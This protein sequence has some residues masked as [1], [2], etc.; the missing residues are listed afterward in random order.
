[1]NSLKSLKVVNNFFRKLDNDKK[2]LI[3]LSGGMDSTTIAYWMKKN[4]YYIQA[5]YFDYSQG[6]TNGERES[7][8]SI[9]KKLEIKLNIIK[10]PLLSTLYQDV[11]DIEKK[12]VINH[13]GD[14]VD[15]FIRAIVYASKIDSNY[16]ITGV[17]SDDLNQVPFFTKKFFK[18]ME[19]LANLSNEK[20]F[21]IL[22]PFLG[23]D[24]SNILKIGIDLDI[25]F[26]E[27]WS[28]GTSFRKQCGICIDCI[29]RKQ[30][31][32]QIGLL[33]PTEYEY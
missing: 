13:L 5:L 6:K 28:C 4:H 19:N 18:S 26:K 14:V 17:H 29:I 24:K 25:P 30:A 7:A 27:T 23:I 2:F 9:A 8:L 10:I 11:L 15:M 12:N 16:I 3:L 20:N 31:F 22:V 32:I 21:R 33:D 1:M